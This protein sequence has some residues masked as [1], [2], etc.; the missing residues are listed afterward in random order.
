[1]KRLLLLCFGTAM[2]MM[3]FIA[4]AP[5]ALACACCAETAWRYVQIEGL[6]AKR[7]A[8][9]DQMRFANQQS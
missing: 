9:I 8:E 5:P 6:S 2:T 7:T 3:A 1:M 4:S